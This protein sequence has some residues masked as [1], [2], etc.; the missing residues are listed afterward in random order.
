MLYYYTFE[1]IFRTKSTEVKLNHMYV[2]LTCNRACLQWSRPEFHY[3]L[4]TRI[5]P[6]TDTN[7]DFPGALVINDGARDLWKDYYIAHAAKKTASADQLYVK[8][9]DQ[10]VV[11][12]GNVETAS[13]DDV[14][15]L[16]GSGF[17]ANKLTKTAEP[18]T[19]TPID[20]MQMVQGKGYFKIEY[21]CDEFMNYCK[22]RTRL[23]GAPDTAWVEEESSASETMHFTGYTR[24]NDTEVQ[25]CASGTAGQSDWSD[26]IFVMVA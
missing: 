6:N 16:E 4:F 15:K 23:K 21:T 18:Q 24:G 14:A 7:P 11:L 26:S 25:I 1:K 17:T 20:L 12:M 2:P 9:I 5:Y 19:A 10:T 13:A 8:I 3:Y 22:G